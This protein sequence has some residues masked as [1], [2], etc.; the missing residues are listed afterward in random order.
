MSKEMQLIT[1][2]NMAVWEDSKQVEEIRKI[3]APKL[4]AQEFDAFVGMGK[5]ANLNPFLREIWAVKYADSSPAQIFVGRDGYRKAAQRNHEYDYHECDAVYTND[6]FKRN[7]ISG[8]IN[9]EYNLKDRG[10][11]LGAYCI[12]KRKNSSRPCYTWVKLSEYSTGKSLWHQQTG[13]PETMIKKV[14]E[15][16]GLRGAFQDLLGGTY[17]EE[18]MDYHA[19]TSLKKAKSEVLLEKLKAAKESSIDAEFS[20]VEAGNM[21]TD[22]QLEEIDL[23][24]HAK[25]FEQDRLAK[26]LKHYNV[27]LLGDLTCMQAQDFIAILSKLP[28]KE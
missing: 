12:V 9:H 5:A 11:L 7:S 1:S 8:E 26:A 13:K 20:E 17:G 28:D 23:L 22:A 2:Q 24:L 10:E 18:E 15:C 3:F 27:T 4:N 21:I 16:Q 19:D 14:A 25:I 6:L